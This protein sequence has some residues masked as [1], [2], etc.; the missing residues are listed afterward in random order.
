[1]NLNKR[2]L[3][4]IA[5]SA[6][7]TA[8]YCQTLFSARAI[9]VGSYVASVM[10]SRGFDLNPAGLVGIRDWDFSTTTYSSVQG[11]AKGFVFHGLAFGKRFLDRHAIGVQYSPGS[12]LEFTVPATVVLVDSTSVA[13][14]RRLVYDELFALGYGV[15]VSERLS[16]G[17]GARLRRE[18]LIDTEYQLVDQDSVAFITP[19]EKIV[20]ANA[21]LVDAGALWNPSDEIT[22]ALVGRNLLTP[23]EHS[24][25]LRSVRLSRTASAEAGVSYDFRDM[26]RLNA[27]ISSTQRGAAGFETTHGFGLSFRAGAYF[28]KDTSPFV[29]AVAGGVGWTYDFL[30]IDLSYLHFLNDE[31]RSGSASLA[32]FDP[33]QLPG[34]DLNSFTRNRVTISLRAMFGAVRESLVRIESVEMAGG[35]YPAAYE[36]FAYRPVGKVRVRN[37][38]RQPV[39]AKAR[40][41]VD[42]LMD[43]PTETDRVYILPGE[44]VEIPFSAVFNDHI[45]GFPAVTIRDGMVYVSA[46]PAEQYDDRFQTRILIH[47][48]N[49]WDGDVHTL[50]YFVTPNDPDVVR[51]SRDI[52]MENANAIEDAPP[53]LRAFHKARVIFDAF[54]GRVMYVGDPRQSADVVQ[55]PSE[56]LTLKGGDCDDMT[57]CFSTLL[58]S[59]GISTA[60]VDVVPPD[61]PEESHIY[62]LFDTGVEPK[63]GASISMNPKRFTTRKNPRG[64]ETI[65]V[66]VETTV[67]R[68]GFEEAWSAGAQRHFDDVEIGLGLAK[69]WVKIVDVY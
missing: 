6:G 32:N 42:R 18:K 13:V 68:Q 24:D 49:D 45:K 47:G 9:G 4:S 35:I 2:L 27:G 11:D 44:E 56:T 53:E 43:G 65:W 30:N 19:G 28:D 16:L 69:G 66:P 48:R 25:E 46:T 3:I 61:R 59:V 54:A 38:S 41:M 36:T 63:F 67:L 31:R 17:L 7:S 60:F 15:R 55:Y 20:E 51:Y 52:L 57:V 5:L 62:L 50:R 39:Y 33:S 29:F 8:A 21:W 1:M 22:L 26:V 58:N 34:V 64:K 37:I 12:L 23:G 14:D 10:D 40:F